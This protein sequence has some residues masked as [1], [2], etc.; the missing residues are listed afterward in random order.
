M[1]LKKT[2]KFK[3]SVKKNTIQWKTKLLFFALLLFFLTYLFL[4]NINYKLRP[5]I[6]N[7]IE[8]TVNKKVYSYIFSM[9][10][11]DT[12]ENENLMDIIYLQKN[13]KGEIVSVDYR[14]NKAYEYLSDSMVSLYDHIGN[15]EFDVAYFD[16]DKNVFF[17]PSGMATNNLLLENMGFK[18][19]CKVELLSDTSMGFKT[20]VSNY[21]I[22]NIL[23][24]LYLVIQ[25][26]NN[27][28]I[29]NTSS[30]FGN[31]YEIVLASKIVMG[32]V[33]AYYGDTIEKMS[34]IVSS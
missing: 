22:N 11:K 13:E 28:F 23:V 14:F 21:G 4:Q 15:V 33:P 20:K 29:P 6:E 18:I 25:V 32:E 26:K 3:T 7:I 30:Q 16:K 34:M 8:T 31:T 10:S 27:I 1:K 5:K 12:L 2:K 24:E 9:F 17:I 19:P